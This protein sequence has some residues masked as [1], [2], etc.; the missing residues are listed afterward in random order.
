M[1]LHEECKPIFEAC[2]ASPA[3]AGC[4]DVVDQIFRRT[5]N[6]HPCISKMFESWRGD[7][8]DSL[9]CCVHQRGFA[10]RHCLSNKLYVQRVECEIKRDSL[11]ECSTL[12]CKGGTPHRLAWGTVRVVLGASVSLCSG[13]FFTLWRG[14]IVVVRTIGGVVV[15][16][17]VGFVHSIEGAAPKCGGTCRL[18]L[19]WF[20]SGA[21]AVGFVVGLAGMLVSLASVMRAVRTVARLG[22]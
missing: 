9:Y 2:K 10:S 3:C 5:P 8:A 19:G 12:S 4:A 6:D 17:F 18:L 20:I 15:H 21:G 11:G 14:C 16:T 22:A 7:C 13:V 1:D